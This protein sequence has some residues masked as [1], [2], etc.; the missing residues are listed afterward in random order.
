MTKGVSALADALVA[1]YLDEDDYE[2]NARRME[3]Y[4]RGLGWQLVPIEPSEKMIEAGAHLSY[5]HQKLECKINAHEIYSAML[6]AAQ[7]E[8]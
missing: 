7:G 3:R 4:L 8:G 2:K 5:S 1:E 6:T